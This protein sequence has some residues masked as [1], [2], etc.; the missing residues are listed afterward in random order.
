VSRLGHNSVIFPGVK[1]QMVAK[2][3]ENLR[4]SNKKTEFHKGKIIS[5]ETSSWNFVYFI[6]LHTKQIS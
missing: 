3:E 6:S 2:K 1:F 4:K 5:N